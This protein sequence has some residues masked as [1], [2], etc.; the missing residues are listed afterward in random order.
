MQLFLFDFLF[1]TELKSNFLSLSSA[2]VH[3]VVF[4]GLF[5]R[6]PSF[7]LEPPALATH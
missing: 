7:A 4:A 3:M 1:E 5:H 2:E 6:K